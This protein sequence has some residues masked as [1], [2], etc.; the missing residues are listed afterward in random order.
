MTIE[1]ISQLESSRKELLDLGLRNSLLN[2]RRRA[3]QISIIDEISAEIYRILV[4]DGREMTFEALPDEQVAELSEL[5]SSD[6]L[7][8]SSIDWG[9]LIAQPDER[10]S[11]RGLPARHVDNKLQTS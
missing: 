6:D 4:I 9:N 3:K 5:D 8:F 11:K 10:Q 7:L 2:H 1:V